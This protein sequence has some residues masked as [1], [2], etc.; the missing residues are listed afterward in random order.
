MTFLR[1]PP[2]RRPA[3]RRP[4]LPLA[5]P[6]PCHVSDTVV[7]HATLPTTP[8]DRFASILDG[9]CRAVAARGGGRDRLHGPLV[10]L[11]WSRISRIAVRFA[12]LAARI[13]AGRQRRYPARR[14][15][16]PAPRRPAQR[17]LPHGP[18]WLLPL[19]P[20]ASGYGSQLQHLL[21]DPEFAALVDAAPQMRRL[22]RPLCRMLGVA[23]P[24]PPRTE[25][26]PPPAAVA[27]AMPPPAAP[28]PP[29]RD[30]PR[31]HAPPDLPAARPPSQPA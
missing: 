23:P 20:Q 18:A 30:P 29:P 24:P 5:Q 12:A 11:I 16:R 1:A 19:V 28:G 26:P 25:P 15:P 22:L 3:H 6:R 4:K 7:T 27:A 10:I 2:P 17:S 14:P 31:F 21:A 8:T 9:L 13:A